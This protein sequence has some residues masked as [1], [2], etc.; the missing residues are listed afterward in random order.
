MDRTG[1][2][3][4]KWLL[5]LQYVC[6]LLNSTYNDTIQGI[7]LQLA[8][9]RT[10]DISSFLTYHFNQPVYYRDIRPKPGETTE[11]RLSLFQ[12]AELK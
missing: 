2:E 9:G 6:D 10:V 1:A 4:N 3:P 12:S 8:Y 5:A 7:P 11:R